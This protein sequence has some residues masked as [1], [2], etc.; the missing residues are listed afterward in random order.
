MSRADRLPGSVDLAAIPVL[1]ALSRVGAR[2]RAFDALMVGGPLLVGLIA[3]VGRTNLTLVLAALYVGSFAAY[4][5]YNGIRDG[6]S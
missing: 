3:L 4:V 5:F 6:E 2:D 1:G